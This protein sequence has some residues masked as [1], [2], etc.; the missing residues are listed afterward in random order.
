[1]QDRW[2]VA[3]LDALFCVAFGRPSAINFYTTN[4]PQDRP[5]SHLSESPGSAVAP[6]PPS[7]VL[8]NETT[9]T[10]YHTAYFQLT[11]PSYE[12]L[13][14]IFHTEWTYSRSAIYGWFSRSNEPGGTGGAYAGDAGG[15]AQGDGPR[16]DERATQNT[17]EASIRLA[18]DMLD[19]YSHLPDGM[20]FEPD[21]TTTESITR[22]RSPVRVNQTLV[23]CVKA[24]MIMCVHSVLS[25]VLRFA[26]AW[27]SL[28]LQRPYLRLDPTAY[29]ESTEICFTAAHTILKAYSVASQAHSSTFWTWWTMTFRVSRQHTHCCDVR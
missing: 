11:I 18:K 9:D 28:C 8:S 24:F 25:G 10:T 12:L 3:G 15:M 20:R 19:W 14:R 22:D 29:P 17:Y 26:N 5:D 6:L 2:T 21:S 13:D 16:V 23:L 7:N 27:T 4:L 1:M